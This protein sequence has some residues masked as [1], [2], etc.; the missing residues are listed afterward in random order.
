MIHIKKMTK[1]DTKTLERLEELEVAELTK[2]EEMP[3]IL[4]AKD[5]TQAGPTAKPQGLT[6]I[7]VSY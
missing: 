5:R 6:L 1:K 3:R 2:P 4:K 7:K